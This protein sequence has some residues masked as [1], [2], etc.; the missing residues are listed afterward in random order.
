MSSFGEK[1]VVIPPAIPFEILHVTEVNILKND[2]PKKAVTSLKKD[3]PKKD[4]TKK[5]LVNPVIVKST[6]PVDDIKTN[7]ETKANPEPYRS[8]LNYRRYHYSNSRDND[9][10]N[11]LKTGGAK[12]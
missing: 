11:R 5:D 2:E 9:W 8:G 10:R 4:I 7:T 3:E 12:Q 6:D 1:P